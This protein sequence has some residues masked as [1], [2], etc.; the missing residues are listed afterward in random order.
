MAPQKRARQHLPAR[1]PR[2][3]PTQG[4]D[5]SI[6][7]PAVGFG[8]LGVAP[9]STELYASLHVFQHGPRIDLH[10]AGK[11]EN[12]VLSLADQ[13]SLRINSFRD[14]ILGDGDAVLIEQ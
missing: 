9:H 10:A 2:L 14:K 5:R 12:Q 6:P 11:A 1:R 3:L 7:P 13:A 8:G 4:R